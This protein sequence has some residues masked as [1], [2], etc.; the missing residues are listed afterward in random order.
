MIRGFLNQSNARVYEEINR[1]P[2]K[3]KDVIQKSGYVL[4]YA[5]TDSV[6][7]KNTTGITTTDQYEKIVSILR[8]ET[9]LPISIEHNFKF[10]VLLSLETSEKIEALKELKQKVIAV[11]TILLVFQLGI[12][13]TI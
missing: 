11:L 3:T 4:I 8:K 10:L 12:C 6:F 5:D 2:I 7:I 1:L 13:T 9:G